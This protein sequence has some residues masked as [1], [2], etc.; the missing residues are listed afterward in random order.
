[1]TSSRHGFTLVEL[2]IVMTIIGLLIGGVLKGQELLE[3]ARMS[4]SAAKLKSYGSA[5][6]TF[7]DIYKALPGDIV[8]PAN[9]IQNCTTAPCS[10]SGN[11]DGILGVLGN[12][13]VEALNAY[14]HMSRAGLISG[15]DPNSTGVYWTASIPTIDF[16]ATRMA[17]IHMNVPANASYLDGLPGIW[18]HSVSV[19]GSAASVPVNAI[20]KF[21]LK[22]DDGRPWNGDVK[23]FSGCGTAAGATNYDPNNVTICYMGVDTG[24]R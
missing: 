2:A 18:F 16:S 19:G 7:K 22:I 23:Q 20:A 12:W 3:N 24:V 6:I 21:D 13:D 11:G 14:L 4:S 10:T 5:M 1:M 9:F 15:V 17:L 8:N